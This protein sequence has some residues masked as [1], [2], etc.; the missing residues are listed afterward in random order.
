[1]GGGGGE[2][3]RRDG[4]NRSLAT[5]PMWR[6]GQPG[7]GH[8]EAEHAEIEHVGGGERRQVHLGPQRSL[9]RTGDSV[10]RPNLTG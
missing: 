3:S 10:E 8:V 5:R 1:M 7:I 4:P 2:Q 6:R 9:S